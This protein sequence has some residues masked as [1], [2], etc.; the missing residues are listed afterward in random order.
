VQA[1]GTTVIQAPGTTGS[2]ATGTASTQASTPQATIIAD[3]RTNTIIVRGT[4]AQVDQIAQII[5]SLDVR[6]PQVNVQVRIQEITESASRS[7]GV[8]WKA[9]FGNFIVNVASSGVKAIFDPTQSLVGFNLGA[10]LNALEQQGMT[11]RVYDGTVTM[12]SGQRSLNN[13]TDS[14][15]ASSG[16]AAHLQSGGRLE[17][18]IPSQAANVP[19][20]Q[21]QI[22]Y[23]VTIDFYNPQV[24]PDGSI[25]V[26]VKGVVNQPKTA[27]TGSTLPNLLDFSNSEAQTTITF[28][29]G[30]TVLLSGLLGTNQTTTT[31]GLPF[32]SSIPVIGSLFGKQSS[33]NDRSQLLVVITGTV[34][35]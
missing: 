6:V 29:S 16:A 19:A 24:A 30:E 14:Q 32:L 34:V 13:S 3:K 33:T 25:T 12:Q 8:D 7:L 28:K 35:Q 20:I 4:Q 26:R 2:A 5:P 27:I 1:D 9:G 15:N 21:R 31:T 11:K 23:G 18:N 22:D 10:T 17:L